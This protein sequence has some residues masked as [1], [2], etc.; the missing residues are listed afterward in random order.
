M[1]SDLGDVGMAGGQ[2]MS[3]IKPD[4]LCM[5]NILYVYQNKYTYRGFG[6][7]TVLP[8][9]R[10][11][12]TINAIRDK[13]ARRIG[14]MPRQVAHHVVQS[15]M[16][17]A[18]RA[19]RHRQALIRHQGRLPAIDGCWPDI[20]TAL[21][22]DGLV[23][24]PLGQLGLAGHRAVLAT[25]QALAAE[26]Q[27]R[28]IAEG[29]AGV[30]FL[31][32]PATAMARHPAIFRF[33]LDP[34]LLAAIETYLGVPVAYDGVTLQVT[35][36]DG[37]AVSTRQWHRDREDR[38]MVKL[39]IYLN[40]VDADGGPFQLL[41][42]PDDVL[43]AAA[44]Q[45][46]FHL[47]TDKLTH[48]MAAG[49]IPPPVTCEGPAGTALF[50]DTARFFHRGKPA[51]GQHRAALFFSYFARRPQHPYFCNR[52]SFSKAELDHLVAGLSPVQQ[53]AAMWHADLPFHWRVIPAAPV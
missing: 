49:T 40:D 27:D 2:G 42:A 38:R 4:G 46:R 28:L 32:V 26:W 22:R 37:R 36:A 1:V 3:T 52:S 45:D 33:G 18:W 19:A 23:A 21:E 34:S 7:R 24:R 30:S 9:I 41:D 13:A 11:D 50:A 44:G 14:V 51:T 10:D 20:V 29:R 31:Q 5:T 43:R 6:R 35:L 15:R 48:A 25:A 12:M 8:T 16:V 47:D 17:D 39:A 53:R